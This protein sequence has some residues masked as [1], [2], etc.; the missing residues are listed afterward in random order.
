M[1]H[2]I[3]PSLQLLRQLAVTRFEGSTLRQICELEPR[4]HEVEDGVIRSILEHRDELI[5]GLDRALGSLI[6]TAEAL[7]AQMQRYVHSR[8]QFIELDASA[9]QEL[10][11]VHAQLVPALR[12]AI[13]RAQGPDELRELLGKALRAHQANLGTL[14]IRLDHEGSGRG[15]VFREVK[16]AEYAAALQLRVLNLSPHQ[17]KTPVLDIGCGERAELVRHLRE[18]GVEAFGVDRFVQEQPFVQQADWLEHS[19]DADHWGTV[20]SHLAFSNHFLHHHLR[21]GGQAERYARKY[22]EILHGLQRGGS[23]VYSPGLPFMETLLPKELYTLMRLPVQRAAGS[24]CD[25]ELCSVY[26]SS[27]FYSCHVQRLP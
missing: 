17:L 6:E 18:Q 13:A 9:Q 22:M 20:I 14:L 5:D 16:C 27:V 21:S 19:I 1:V 10:V 4:L 23:F 3:P 11:T 26:G 8:N 7:S 12:S 2:E 15:V 24:V 25:D